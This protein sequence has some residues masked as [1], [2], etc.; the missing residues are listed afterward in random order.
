MALR[1]RGDLWHLWDHSEELIGFR[2]T[3]VVATVNTTTTRPDGFPLAS[4]RYGVMRAGVAR[5]AAARFPHAA[6]WWAAQ[7]E[8]GVKDF[9]I[10]PVLDGRYL[11][12]LV[13]KTNWWQDSNPDQVESSLLAMR[14]HADAHPHLRFCVPPPGAGLGRLPLSTSLELCRRHLDDRFIIC[15]R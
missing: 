1:Y 12:F 6:H 15:V 11:G 10:L 4:D 13:T 5:Q 14:T 7:V 2:L 8:A 3:V 9:A